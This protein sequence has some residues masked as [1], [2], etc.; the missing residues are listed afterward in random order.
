MGGHAGLADEFQD[1]VPADR[2]LVVADLQGAGLAGAERDAPEEERGSVAPAHD[3]SRSQERRELVALEPKGVSLGGSSSGAS[4]VDGRVRGLCPPRDT[5]SGRSHAP[6]SEPFPG[7][8]VS[9]AADYWRSAC[10]DVL[11]AASF[12]GSVSA[13]IVGAVGLPDVV[14][15]RQTPQGARWVGGC[16]KT[17]VVLLCLIQ[18]PANAQLP[19]G[20]YVKDAAVAST[21]A[22]S[23]DS[24]SS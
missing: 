17:A 13:A 14:G 12:T 24:I 10:V 6:G 21:P 16:G 4:G 23:L 9:S 5:R 20:V 18:G 8:R 19:G 7:D 2:R 1:T 3:R 11:L 22:S 15:V